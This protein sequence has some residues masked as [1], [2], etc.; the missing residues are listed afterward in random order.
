MWAAMHGFWEYVPAGNY[1]RLMQGRSVVMSSTP[2]EKRSHIAA[3][4]QA[5]GEVLVTGLGLGLIL[6]AILAKPEVQ[7]VTVVE[8]SSEVID[9]VW[10]A[11]SAEPRAQII[12]ADALEW[13][14]PRGKR[15]N[16]VWHDIWQDICSDNL[17][18]MKTLHRRYGRCSDWQGSWERAR[19]QR[20]RA[21]S[22][23]R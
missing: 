14:P 17:E 12:H 18:Q 7:G 15:Y 6:N 11:F 2:A 8:K 4:L 21:G 23:Q 13:K 22:R 9:L 10:P 19:C 20:L 3:W 1:H 5:K 16:A